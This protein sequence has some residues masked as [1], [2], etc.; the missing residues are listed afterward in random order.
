MGQ[1]LSEP[2]VDKVMPLSI[3]AAAMTP[4]WPSSF[5]AQQELRVNIA[6]NFFPRG[7]A[8]ST[9]LIIADHVPSC[10]NRTKVRMIASSLA[11]APCKDGE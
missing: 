9:T 5:A 3:R 10:R 1:T 2:V 4:L 7:I 6:H 8:L 11:S